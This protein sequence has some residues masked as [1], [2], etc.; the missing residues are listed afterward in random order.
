MWPGG[1]ARP[2]LPPN[3]PPSGGLRSELRVD[4]EGIGVPLHTVEG[5]RAVRREGEDTGYIGGLMPLPI[6]AR[7]AVKP[8]PAG[9][10]T[11]MT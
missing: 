9:V 2:T 5:E 7:S 10:A 3:R 8:S 11:T 1:D 6:S 4:A